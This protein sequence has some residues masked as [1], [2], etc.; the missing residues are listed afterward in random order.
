MSLRP[1]CFWFL[2]SFAALPHGA[3]AEKSDQLPFQQQTNTGQTV[4]AQ[5]DFLNSLELSD[6]GGYVLAYFVFRWID[7]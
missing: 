1:T 2:K 5:S 6:F 7:C 4:A 3:P